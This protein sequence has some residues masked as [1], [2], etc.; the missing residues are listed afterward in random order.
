[1]IVKPK[2]GNRFIPR[3]SVLN[4]SDIKGVKLREWYLFVKGL[5]NKW[6]I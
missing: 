5:M 4:I 2:Y 6:D 3:V 1:M